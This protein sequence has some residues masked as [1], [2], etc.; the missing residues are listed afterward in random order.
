[1]FDAISKQLYGHFGIKCGIFRLQVFEGGNVVDETGAQ[2]LV[3][4]LVG[5]VL[6]EVED[7]VDVF[8]GLLG[9]LGQGEVLEGE[10]LEVEVHKFLFEGVDV[11]V[12][13]AI[14][15]V[16]VGVGFGVFGHD[17]FIMGQAG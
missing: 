6:A 13:V 10:G 14:E 4:L 8:E 5:L 7:V 16:D 1:M 11:V 3:E 17:Y 9:M 15:L 12:E 2:G